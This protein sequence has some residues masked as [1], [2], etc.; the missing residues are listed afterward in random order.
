MAETIIWTGFV[1]AIVS[2]IVSRIVG[3]RTPRG[4]TVLI[5][6][7]DGH[8]RVELMAELKGVWPEGVI[9]LRLLTK[10]GKHRA[11]LGTFEDEGT[12]AFL[13]ETGLPRLSVRMEES[14][15]RI[16]FWQHRQPPGVGGTRRIVL[17]L[18]PD[19][20]HSLEFMHEDGTCR[21]SLGV[22]QDGI[23]FLALNDAKGNVIWRAP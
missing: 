23:A 20:S 16:I 18:K 22:Q 11:G 21:A 1:A 9:G 12:L 19:G 15:P 3:S 17:G 7:P 8:A 5:E 13:D 6:D 14:Y 4:R 10:E 2:L